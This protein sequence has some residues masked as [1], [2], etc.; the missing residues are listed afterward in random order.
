MDG[1]SDSWGQVNHPNNGYIK[2]QCYTI[3]HI[4]CTN[5][6]KTGR[7]QQRRETRDVFP[8][9]RSLL[10]FQFWWFETS[11]YLFLLSFLLEAPPTVYS[12][13]SF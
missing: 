3:T 6:I 11:G 7:V 9:L 8:A 2:S 10:L 4:L 12:D 1:Q 13:L 5:N